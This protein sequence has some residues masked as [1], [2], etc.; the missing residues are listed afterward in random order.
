MTMSV[1]DSTQ[2]FVSKAT[3]TIIDIINPHT[4]KTFC[5]SKTRDDLLT[6]G[7]K[8]VEL[9][10]VGDFLT[11]KAAQQRTPITWK[12]VNKE[13]FY[14][15]LECLPPATGTAGWRDFLIGEPYDHDAL[16]GKPRYQGYRRVGKQYFQSSRPMTVTEFNI[17]VGETI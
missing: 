14:Y 2:C 8:D 15:A 6:E 9:M 3:G 7:Y 12:Y 17:E 11:W 10:T 5:L 1:N 4:G 16:N 13:Q